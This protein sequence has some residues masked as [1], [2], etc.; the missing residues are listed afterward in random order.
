MFVLRLCSQERKLATMDA[1]G[2]SFGDKLRLGFGYLGVFFQVCSL[3]V[4][5]AYLYA[6][7]FKV[8]A[9][10][11][12]L[13]S[14][15]GALFN[16]LN[17]IP[18]AQLADSGWLN[19]AM[20]TVFPMAQWGRRA[21]VMCMGIPLLAISCLLMWLCPFTSVAAVAW[22]CLTYFVLANGA[23][24]CSNALQSSIQE[25]FPSSYLRADAPVVC[26]LRVCV[27]LLWCVRFVCACVRVR[28]GAAAR[29]HAQANRRP[30][31]A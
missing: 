31:P 29:H 22:Y 27:R 5:S 20:P 25:R 4:H 6:Y 17:G 18:I 11:L 28:G 2:V 13:A 3:S 16:A 8:D 14:A 9:T 1:I 21:P 10:V 12:G 26:G 23:T 24:C 15:G 30:S 19:R 7:Y